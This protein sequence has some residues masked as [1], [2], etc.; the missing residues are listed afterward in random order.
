MN[1]RARSAVS[2]TAVSSLWA[3]TAVWL[4]AKGRGSQ[5]SA[6]GLPPQVRKRQRSIDWTCN[7]VRVSLLLLLS[8][9]VKVLMKRSGR[10]LLPG[11]GGKHG[12]NV[13]FTTDGHMGPE[14]AQPQVIE[15]QLTR[16]LHVEK[17]T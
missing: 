14:T 9:F 4:C 2:V 12:L 10:L 1:G 6:F 5:L 7:G 15:T 8:Q 3:F 17:V 13:S 16:S 11:P